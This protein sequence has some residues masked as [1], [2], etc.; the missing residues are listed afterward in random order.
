ML[1]LVLLVDIHVV[2]LDDDL[3]AIRHFDVLDDSPFDCDSNDFHGLV[4]P[5]SFKRVSMLLSL[6]FL[7]LERSASEQI[8]FADVVDSHRNVVLV[9]WLQCI[10]VGDWFSGQ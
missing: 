5:S 10:V 3:H 2:I 1:K 4:F 8:F 6:H 7:D 9:D